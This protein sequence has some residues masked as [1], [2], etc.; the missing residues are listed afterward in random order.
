[1][2]SYKSLIIVADAGSLG[3]TTPLLTTSLNEE[4]SMANW[5]DKHNAKLT[6]AYVQRR[7]AGDTASH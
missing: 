2:A 1:V 7:A 5:V 4:R 3:K 6:L